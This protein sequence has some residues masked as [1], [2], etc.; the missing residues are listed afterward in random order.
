MP[1]QVTS[2]DV[3]QLPIGIVN[4]VSREL[5]T[6]RSHRK[7]SADLKI[8][9]LGGNSQPS[10]EGA[11]SP[12]DADRHRPRISRQC[13]S[14][15]SMPRPELIETPSAERSMS[16]RWVSRTKLLLAAC[17]RATVPESFRDD[18]LPED[19]P[20]Q[21][22]LER[23]VYP[24]PLASMTEAPAVSAPRALRLLR[25][26]QLHQ[27]SDG[28]GPAILPDAHGHRSRDHRQ[29]QRPSR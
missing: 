4:G 8:T 7:D 6:A 18:S 26:D 29:D 15:S 13:R 27:L 5:R 20:R 10:C 28:H 1:L 22:V 25:A 12:F 2:G 17:W 14:L 9:M 3:I 19:R 21:C 24:T 11:H 23:P 16:S